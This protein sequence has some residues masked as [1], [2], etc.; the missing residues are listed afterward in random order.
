MHFQTKLIPV[1]ALAWATLA[2]AWP[3]PDA[4]TTLPPASVTITV[5]TLWPVDDPYE[6]KDVGNPS[7]ALLHHGS[8]TVTSLLSGTSSASASTAPN[9]SLPS[10]EWNASTTQRLSTSLTTA[11]LAPGYTWNPFDAKCDAMSEK[12]EDCRATTSCDTSK[13]LHPV[14]RHGECVCR[15]VTCATNMD[16]EQERICREDDHVGVCRPEPGLPDVKGLC[17]CKPLVIGCGEKENS[18]T[19]CSDQ[20]DCTINKRIFSLWSEFGQ[21][22]KRDPEGQCECQT[23]QC[24]FDKDGTTGDDFCKERITCPEKAEVACKIQWLAAPND[25]GGYCTCAANAYEPWDPED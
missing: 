4:N 23:V 12:A 16:C 2:R 22:T 20:I 14:C 17:K 6:T 15:Q 7:D 1:A 18:Q 10:S 11:A 5:P 13:G 24:P 3:Q 8:S 19:W 9:L 25:M 21:C